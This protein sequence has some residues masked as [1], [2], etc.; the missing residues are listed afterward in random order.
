[1]SDKLIDDGPVTAARLMIWLMNGWQHC[2]GRKPLAIKINVS[3]MT[4]REANILKAQC[5]G[6][7]DAIDGAVT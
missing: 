3:N 5:Q 4:L 6:V 7:I 2:G 1:M